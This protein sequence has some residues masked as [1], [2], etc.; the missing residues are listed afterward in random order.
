MRFEQIAIVGVGLIG[1]SVGLAAKA[2][3]IAGRVAGIGRDEHSLTHALKLGAVDSLS[4]DLTDG[5]SGAELVVVCTPVDR[6]AEFVLNA[7]PHC[8]AGTIFTDTGSTKANIVAAVEGKLPQGIAFVPAHPLAGSEKN[9][10]A[11]A[12]ADLFEGRL[13]ILTPREESGQEVARVESF[14]GA[15][16]SRVFRMT[17]EDHDVIL[18]GTSH[19]PH[20]VATALSAVTPIDWLPYSAGG[21]R[22]TTRIAGGDPEI[23]SAIFLDNRAPL[24]AAL[25]RFTN[26]IELLQRLL[27]A[28][29]G[30][31]LRQWLSEAKRVRDALGS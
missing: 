6:I 2:R 16:G 15:L 19:L 9:G 4:L 18:A 12:R 11:N 24:L 27:E 3:G 14:W 21:L 5:V 17:P 30:A 8:R 31:G 7:A 28:G 29:D 13:T 1:G 23:W 20:A 26:R 10:V 22:D 25:S